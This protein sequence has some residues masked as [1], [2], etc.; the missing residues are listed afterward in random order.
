MTRWMVGPVLAG[1]AMVLL[2]G[3]PMGARQSQ[4]PAEPA[5]TSP[6]APGFAGVWHYNEKESVNA[7]TGRPELGPNAGRRPGGAPGAPTRQPAVTVPAANP[8]ATGANPGA[9]GGGAPAGGGGNWRGDPFAMTPFAM[10]EY[11]GFVRDLME[12]PFEITIRVSSDSVTF[13]DDL[14]RE[15]TFPTDGRKQKYQLSASRFEARARWEGPRLIKEVEASH[16]FK[17]TEQYFLSDDGRRLFAIL[18][19]GEL[20]KDAPVN[21]V[22]RVYDRDD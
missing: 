4:S 15:L 11:R 19:V 9:F 2:T 18:R 22:N 5:S 20:K 17:M 21:G 1:A 3:V 10:A 6:S 7:L 16:G 14:D 13:K 12:V 8:P